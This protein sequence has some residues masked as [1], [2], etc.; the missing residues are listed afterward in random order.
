MRTKRM[1]AALALGAG[2]AVIVP[3]TAHASG[4]EG[5]YKSCSG[6]NNNEVATRGYATGTQTHT[7]TQYQTTFS[8]SSSY[9]VKI[10]NARLRTANWEV[11]TTGTLSGSGTYAYC[12]S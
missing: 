4:Y 1:M 8:Y 10:F 5:G 9:A 3:G 2:L 12:P 11:Y 7:Q 6:V